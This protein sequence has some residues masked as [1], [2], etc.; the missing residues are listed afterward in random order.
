MYVSIWSGSVLVG[1][2][3]VVSYMCFVCLPI[4][5]LTSTVPSTKTND[6]IPPLVTQLVYR[7]RLLDAPAGDYSL[8]C[9]DVATG[10]SGQSPLFLLSTKRRRRKLYGPIMHV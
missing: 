8:V 4:E 6:S 1:L 9:T 10:M 3:V 7:F 2:C 5:S